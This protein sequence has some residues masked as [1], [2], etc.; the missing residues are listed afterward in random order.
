EQLVFVI[1]SVLPKCKTW[2]DFIAELKSLG[3]EVKQGAHIAVKMPDAKRF[4]RLSS[5]PDGY[6]EK[7]I[8]ARLSGTM[9]FEP[10]PLRETNAKVPKLLIDIQEKMAEGKGEGYRQWASVHNVKQMAKTLIYVKESGVDSYEELEQ[11]CRDACD[12]MMSVNEK[13]K[14]IEIEQQRI[15]ELQKHIGV[16]GK[17]RTVYNKYRSLK[18][19]KDK[20]VYYEA[21]RAVIEPCKVAVKYFDAQGYKGKLPSI[22]SLKEEWAELEKERRKA[23]PAY[24]AANQKFKDLCVAKSNLYDMLDIGKKHQQSRGRGR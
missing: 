10:K 5:L 11:K 6:D 9:K 22:N 18:N 23:Y 8:R 20:Q 19:P 2:E 16:Y 3:C 14:A 21:N 17:N 1:D 24:K 15:N 4:A 13:I 12:E 7:S